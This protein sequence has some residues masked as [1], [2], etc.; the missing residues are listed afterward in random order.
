MDSEKKLS[1]V[2]EFTGRVRIV[3]ITKGYVSQGHTP[4]REVSRAK[5]VQFPCGTPFTL[6]VAVYFGASDD[7]LSFPA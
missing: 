1:P 7:A 3:S 6:T 4:N 5:T 2:E